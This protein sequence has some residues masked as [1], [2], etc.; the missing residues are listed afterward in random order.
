MYLSHIELERIADTIFITAGD[1]QNA[2][3]SKEQISVCS[4][5]IR[6][7]DIFWVM[8]KQRRVIDLSFSA[9]F[10]V[11][12]TRLWNKQHVLPNGYIDLK[13]GEIILARTHERIE[14]PKHLVGKINTRSSYAR[15]GLSTACNC[16]L[17]NPGYKGHVP[18]ELVNSTNNIIRI[19]PFLP[20][21]QVF[22]MR[23]DGEVVEDYAS[24]R[25]ESKYNDD[26]GGPSVWWR[27]SLVKKVAKSI[28]F[29]QV[30]EYSIKTLRE[31]FNKIDDD[32]LQRFDRLLDS[33]HQSSAE[34]FIEQFKA[35]E[36]RKEKF[37]KY[38]RGI[39][40]WGAPGSF[41]VS[42]V[43]FGQAFDSG[44][45]CPSFAAYLV[46]AVFALS[47]IPFLYYALRAERKY[48]GDLP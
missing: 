45:F 3:S 5:N 23:V 24:E 44:E 8:K 15:M 1:E 29:A 22:L 33:A 43:Q 40:K 10:E 25:F 37:Y 27:D 12:P 9:T 26:E 4:V 18:L 38:R 2:F 47:V 36:K 31:T 21:C 17:I 20:L 6:V 7:G 41:F 42:L 48:Y 16:D 28:N 32:G 35:S 19:R 11:S 34:A 14:M 30:G 39:S 13:P 46:W